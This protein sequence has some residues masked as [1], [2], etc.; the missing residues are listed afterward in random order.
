M[1]ICRWG[2]SGTVDGGSEVGRREGDSPAEGD[3]SGESSHVELDVT[4]DRDA[5]VGG[6]DVSI[7]P[8]MS[9]SIN[10]VDLAGLLCQ[11]PDA[12]AIIYEIFDRALAPAPDD[13]TIEE[14]LVRLH[15]LLPRSG[16]APKLQ[17]VS[18]L[19]ARCAVGNPKLRAAFATYGEQW[20]A[21]GRQVP[22]AGP[23]ASAEDAS[24]GAGTREPAPAAEPASDPCLLVVIYED[25]NGSG[26]FWLELLLYRDGRDAERQE[27]DHS[28]V[29]LKEI[30]AQL[31]LRL[32]VIAGNSLGSP[33][34][35]FAV[36]EK[37]LG[38]DFD[39]WPMRI[40][41]K[42]P[43]SR[44]F[45]LGEKYRVVVRDLERMNPEEVSAEDRGMWESRWRLLRAC[46][47]SAHNAH[48][49]VELRSE[50]TYHSLRATLW[51][52]RAGSVVLALLPARATEAARSGTIGKAVT[53]LLKAGFDAGLPAAVWLRY[54]QPAKTN[55]T[56]ASAPGVAAA[57]VSAGN[58]E[59]DREYLRGV[60]RH[61]PLRDLPETVWSH[62]LEA[63]G[64]RQPGSHPGR[65]LSLLW[66]DPG[67]SWVPSPTLTS[68]SLS[69]NGDDI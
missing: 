46:A 11:L 37:L 28:P 18:E 4:A 2:G 49:E 26:S 65:R 29:S 14:L 44:D 53:G 36:P 20:A 52:D 61:A 69:V 15:S 21:E 43:P 31:R 19:A 40:Q 33:L 13:A 25:Y 63:E 1:L 22:A 39:Q 3:S 59:D 54:H 38:E 62:R 55:G 27:C 58:D 5:I 48:R 16:E 66:A 60:V 67:R 23:A 9:V 8:H 6:R 47:D 35:E 34:I 41:P 50:V 42:A 7:G 10:I 51:K 56:S 17:Q 45:R 64:N 57:G 12:V 68:P 24:A 32:P 30:K